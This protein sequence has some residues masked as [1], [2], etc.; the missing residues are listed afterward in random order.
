M[1][2]ATLSL[3]ATPAKRPTIR[4]IAEET[5]LSVT[6]VSYALRGERMS[7]A[8]IERV[9]AKAEELGYIA[10]PV[11]RALRGG[12]TGTVGLLVGS[13]ADF[14]HQTLAHAIQRELRSHGL[15]TLLADAD[16]NPAE[17]LALAQ[18][19][20][21][22]RVDGR[23]QMA[24]LAQGLGQIDRA[25]DCVDVGLLRRDSRQSSGRVA[26]GRPLLK[27]DAGLGVH[28]S[29]IGQKVVVK[30]QDVAGVWAVEEGFER[31][32]HGSIG[33]S[34][35]GVACCVLRRQCRLALH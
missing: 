28:R 30:V 9:Q 32:G 26:V 15:H 12:R 8:T 34:V 24:V 11:A 5:G 25:D 2:G 6:A 7:A 29:G 35:L 21:A 17:E 3:V 20:A 1:W 19:L 4:Q 14:W 13:L 10:D 16:G 18:R 22:Q 31:I 23:G 33:C 27:K